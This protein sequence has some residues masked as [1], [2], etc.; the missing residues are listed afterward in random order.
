LI[1]S[2]RRAF[3]LA[4][5]AA[6]LAPAGAHAEVTRSTI[7]TP[8]HPAFRLY[9]V[10]AKA[11]EPLR[12]AGTTNGDEG[13]LLDIICTR[14][15]S[16][17]VAKANVAVRKDGT[18]DT[19]F[20]LDQLKPAACVLRAVPYKRG[21]KDVD[22]FTGPLVALTYFN[23][24]AATTAV[25]GE[26]TV[27]FDYEVETGHTH[28]HATVS[29]GAG[30]KAHFGVR[31]TLDRYATRTW[32]GAGRIDAV[33]VDGVEAYVG[34]AIPRTEIEGRLYAPQGFD[35]IQAKVEVDPATGA[36]TIVE[37]ARALRCD[38]KCA[39]VVETGVRL[40]RT[41]TLSG[42]HARA[43]VRDRWVSTDGAAHT[44]R[45]QY[46]HQA[47]ASTWRFPGT[48]SF[49]A[50]APVEPAA[51]TLLTHDGTPQQ[52]MGAITFDPVPSGFA[53]DK[54]Y[55]AV[56][57]VTGNVPATVTRLFEVGENLIQDDVPAP[58][59]DPQPGPGAPQGP[60]DPQPDNPAIDRCLVPRVRSG[61]KLKAAKA[62][63]RKGNCNVG[64]T[65][66]VRSAKVKKGRVVGLSRKGGTKLTR[67]AR[68]GIKVS[69]GR[70]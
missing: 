70:R 40:E 3:P 30:L 14:G 48:P 54:P 21:G 65:R 37:L 49:R 69:R 35:G 42:E 5:L 16:F 19:S 64:T 29:S 58:Q 68:V 18:F 13:D 9:E 20:L 41:V 24:R 11:A 52:A 43:E 6:V 4:V 10:E 2:L 39:V 17:A 50:P 51:K 25:R 7:T 66:K 27:P 23:P 47:A 8:A 55:R 28:G 67:G 53:F 44:V 61:A 63:I 56:E 32:D 46:G 26:E 38:D 60:G 45:A 59:P 1:R 33:L 57:A 12:V 34:G 15:D 31:P 36:V 22:A 62:A